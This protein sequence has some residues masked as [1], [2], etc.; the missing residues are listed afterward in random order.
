MSV[1]VERFNG[2]A[3]EYARFRKRY[4]PSIILPLLREWCGLLPEWTVADIAAGTGMLSDVLLANGN[5]VIAI[6]PNAKMREVCTQLHEGDLQ[7]AIMNGTA[8][9]TGL[10]GASVEMVTVGRALHWFDF[11]AAMREFRR[12]LRP[13]GWVAVIAFGR[14]DTES[15]ENIA[16]EN[17]FRPYTGSR[18]GTSASHAVYRKLERAFEGGEFHQVQIP[19]VM[20]LGW[21]ELRGL[22][23][24]LSYSPLPESDEF[25]PFEVELR[26]F[27]D[28]YERNGG[29]TLA[30]SYWI[31]AGRFG[32]QTSEASGEAVEERLQRS[33]DRRPGP[34]AWPGYASG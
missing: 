34:C 31:N 15:Q 16:Y 28:Q 29:V 4:D 9:S 26:R 30:T 27:F 21:V 32:V 19:G 25:G 33:A 7:L 14:M 13:G 8:E 12:V 17:L 18:E 24:S 23:L 1:H 2:R 6:E 20:K 3:E 5:R 11:N 22:T 10:S